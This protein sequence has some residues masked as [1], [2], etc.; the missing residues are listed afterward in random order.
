MLVD[1]LRLKHL[2]MDVPSVFSDCIISFWN[3]IQEQNKA[4][5][6]NQTDEATSV[7]VGKEKGIPLV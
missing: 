7:T 5:G 4:D 3:W 6:L 1:L 2:I